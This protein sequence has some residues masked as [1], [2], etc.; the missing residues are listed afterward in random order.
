MNQQLLDQN[1]EDSFEEDYDDSKELHDLVDGHIEATM[2]C[3]D[4]KKIPNFLSIVY[5]N[6]LFYLMFDIDENAV[7][8]QNYDFLFSDIDLDNYSEDQAEYARLIR[9]VRD[10]QPCSIVLTTSV[11]NIKYSD[12]KLHISYSP[13]IVK[14]EKFTRNYGI[15]SFIKIENDKK[16]EMKE[17][18]VFKNEEEQFTCQ[19]CKNPNYK[20][21]MVNDE[22]WKKYGN[23]NGT[24]C[25]K[26]FEKR[27]GRKLQPKDFGQYLNA[28]CNKNNPDVLKIINQKKETNEQE[29][30]EK[31]WKGYT[32]K[33]MKTMFGKRYPNCVKKTK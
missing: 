9:A 1:I 31:C 2:I 30:T 13:H 23:Q 25:L 32:Q 12:F 29:I 21:Y 19:D 11:E 20:M 26:C 16:N 10:R 7:I 15:F 6:K 33:G 27:L 14:N 8:G 28:L 17:Q 22:L 4:N 5:A 24:L 18:K 3:R